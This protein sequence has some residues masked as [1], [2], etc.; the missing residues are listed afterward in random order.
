MSGIKKFT[1][2]WG[3]WEIEG[4][5]GEG[6]F[7]KVYKAYREEFGKKYFC[8]IKHISIPKDD[9]ELKQIM[10]ESLSDDVTVASEYFQQI[11]EDITNEINIMY[12]LNGNTN[13]VAYQEH[14]IQQKANGIG[15]DIFIKMELLTEFSDMVQG[16]SITTHDIVNIGVDICT[17]LEVCALKNLIHRDIKPQNIFVNEDGKYKLGD[18]GISRQLEKTMSGLSK[19]GT[20]SYMA[21]EVYKGEDYGANVDIYSLG[22]VMYRLVNGNRLPFLPLAPNP[23]RWDDND[24][25]MQKR[26][27]GEKISAPSFA[28]K[29]LSKIILKMCAFDREE[30]YKTAGEVKKDLLQILKSD[31]KVIPM[32]APIGKKSLTKEESNSK[33][34]KLEKTASAVAIEVQVEDKTEKTE[35]AIIPKEAIGDRTEK[36][37][38][39]AAVKER[40]EGETKKVT[41]IDE[42]KKHKKALIGIA[43]GLVGVIVIIG[44][45][46]LGKGDTPTLEIT[47][48]PTSSTVKLWSGWVKTLPQSVSAATYN[49]NKKS[50]KQKVTMYKFRTK[51]HGY[52]ETTKWVNYYIKGAKS[53]TTGTSKMEYLCYRYARYQQNQCD[54]SEKGS[55]KIGKWYY[56]SKKEFQGYQSEPFNAE[57]YF[58]YASTEKKTEW[59]S[60]KGG[61]DHWKYTGQS[62]DVGKKTQYQQITKTPYP[63]SKWSEWQENEVKKT[64]GCEVRTKKI[65]KTITL[66]QYQ[67]K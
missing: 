40:I 51:S 25:A 61:K 54:K 37:A 64:K 50:S 23:I 60:Y 12:T 36:T 42:I 13:I 45:T 67:Q 39:A 19:K 24:E 34:D 62:R 41:I 56:S 59:L 17:A 43:L 46:S 49:I 52:T 5:L 16:N 30:R 6:S 4:L 31:D 8:A 53:K 48:T 18:F 29:D 26:M 3:I 28:D 63:W 15:Y 14:Q 57:Q 11:V 38:S 47:S 27:K 21:P 7:G 9:A 65:N 1:P 20:Y 55:V 35:S 32:V 66:Y 44:I 2:L 58:C 10:R 33:N 22:M